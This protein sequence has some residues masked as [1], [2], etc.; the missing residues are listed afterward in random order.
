M[1]V[2]WRLVKTRH[3][4]QAFSGEG[5]RIHGGRWN[6]P[7][8]AAVYVSDTQALATLEVLTGLGGAAVLADYSLIRV[9]FDEEMVQAVDAESLPEGWDARPPGPG[10]QGVG[11][12]WLETGESVVLRVP[13]VIVPAESN[14]VLN[15]RHADFG[16]VGVGQAERFVIDPRL[17]P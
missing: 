14:Y 9:S 7:G 8:R 11:D 17:G 4:A 3:A 12:R 6:S 16:A 15:P 1:P 5:A 10:S 2:A 13:S